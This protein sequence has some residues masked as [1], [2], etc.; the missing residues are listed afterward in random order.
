MSLNFVNNYEFRTNYLLLKKKVP[1]ANLRNKDQS[2]RLSELA[3]STATPKILK[4]IKRLS[5]NV[6]K[7][8]STEDMLNQFQEQNHLL[9]YHLKNKFMNK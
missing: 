7:L 3:L 9:I 4:D 5:H 1:F 8:S 2:K 6:Y